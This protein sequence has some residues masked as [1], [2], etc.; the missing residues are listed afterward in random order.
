MDGAGWWACQSHAQGW[1][2]I[3]GAVQTSTFCCGAIPTLLQPAAETRTS[4][5]KKMFDAR[6]LACKCTRARRARD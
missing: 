3:C 2:G 6:S 4:A 1:V 5:A